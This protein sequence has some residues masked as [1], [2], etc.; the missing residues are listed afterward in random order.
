MQSNSSRCAYSEWKPELPC[1]VFLQVVHMDV[2]GNTVKLND[3][4]QISYDKCLI[5]TGKAFVFISF[6]SLYY[7]RL[8][9]SVALTDKLLPRGRAVTR[10]AVIQTWWHWVCYLLDVSQLLWD[11]QF[12]PVKISREGGKGGCPSRWVKALL[13][14]PAFSSSKNTQLLPC[15]STASA[16]SPS[17]Y[18]VV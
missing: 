5:A 12:Y 11:V 16:S 13:Y 14:S 4:T 3:G 10:R 6:C 15:Q 9:I 8:L 17:S 1:L 18:I 7:V 2:R